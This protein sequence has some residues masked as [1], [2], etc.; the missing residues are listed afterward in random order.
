MK[1]PLMLF[2][3]LWVCAFFSQAFALKVHDKIWVASAEIGTG[4]ILSVVVA[5]KI[6]ANLDIGLGAGFDPFIA[7]SGDTKNS[8]WLFSAN[9][10]SEYRFAVKEG[11]ELSGRV[12]A[13]VDTLTARAGGMASANPARAF[14]ITPALLG[15]YRN[16][17]AALSG[18]FMFAD[19]GFSFIPQL[20]VGYKVRF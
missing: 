18:V 19:Q 6:S 15:G 3:V 20:G 4:N 16:V 11:V 2:T 10:C 1:K 13:G 8:F 12:Q 14:D 17:Y 5:R 7:S 9:V